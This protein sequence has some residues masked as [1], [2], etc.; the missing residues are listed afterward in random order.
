M[1]F[2]QK[3]GTERNDDNERNDDTDDDDERKVG[4]AKNTAMRHRRVGGRE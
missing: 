1:G 2:I 3:T 4:F